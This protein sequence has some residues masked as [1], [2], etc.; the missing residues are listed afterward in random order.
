MPVIDFVVDEVPRSIVLY[1]Q[2]DA[3]KLTLSNTTLL[4][5]TKL[6][7]TS[8][9]NIQ[10][11]Y[12]INKEVALTTVLQVAILIALN[13]QTDIA[14]AYYAISNPSIEEKSTM[15]ASVL[16]KTLNKRIEKYIPNKEH[17]NA[18]KKTVDK[19]TDKIISLLQLNDTTNLQKQTAM[20]AAAT[21]IATASVA[22]TSVATVPIAHAQVVSEP[23]IDISVEMP[24]PATASAATSSVSFKDVILTYYRNIPQGKQRFME[25]FET[26]IKEL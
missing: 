14:D 3:K 17:L 19:I 10:S 1:E 7:G 8:Y 23:S 11:L 20:K 15:N 9:E 18:L 6:K 5:A 4:H 12:K 24:A 13:L 26:I 22:A 25:L 21:T 2:N 16:T